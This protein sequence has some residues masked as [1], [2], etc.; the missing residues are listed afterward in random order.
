MSLLLNGNDEHGDLVQRLDAVE[1]SVGIVPTPIASEGSQD[2][3][4]TL[5]ELISCEF[6]ISLSHRFFLC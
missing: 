1:C 5:C 3:V 4:R 2:G 6:I